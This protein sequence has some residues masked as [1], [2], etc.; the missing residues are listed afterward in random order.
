MRQFLCHRCD[1]Q[2]GGTLEL[3]TIRAERSLDEGEQTRLAAAIAA[4]DANLLAAQDAEGGLL[5]QGFGSPPKEDVAQVNHGESLRRTAP[6]VPPA[7]R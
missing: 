1:A 2:L 4:H 6:G 3:T 7:G 5:E